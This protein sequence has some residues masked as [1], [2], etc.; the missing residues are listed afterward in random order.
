MAALLVPALAHPDPLHPDPCIDM[1]IEKY[2][3]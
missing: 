3:W 1:V 2:V